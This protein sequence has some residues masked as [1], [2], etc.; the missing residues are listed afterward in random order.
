MAVTKRISGTYTIQSVNPTDQVFINTSTVTIDGNLVVLGNTTTVDTSTINLGDQYLT[1]NANLYSN[2]APTLNAGL[3]INRGS[4]ANVWL[5]W[6]ETI[7]HWQI[8]ND[9]STYGNIATNLTTLSNV[10]SDT[11][12]AISANLDLRGYG[13]WDSVNTSGNVQV[14]IGSVGNGGTGIHVTNTQYSNKEVMLKDRS[15]AYSILFG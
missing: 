9:G 8:T 15:V 4:S 14:S 7:K 6:N 10:Y 12:P 1:L 11:A 3:T 2:T 13:I 5:I